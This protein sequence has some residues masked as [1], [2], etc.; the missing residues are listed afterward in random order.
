MHAQATQA[1]SVLALI[2]VLGAA[3]GGGESTK[4]DPTPS[5]MSAVAGTPPQSA[6]VGTAV[7]SAPAV[8]LVDAS[9]AGV[10]GV[11]VVFSVTA[12]GGTVEGGTAKSDVN[13]VAAVT[14][15]TLGTTAGVNTL[16]AASGN[17][18]AVT[19][20]ATGLPGAASVLVKTSTD[21]QTAVAGAAVAAAP[22][23]TVKD[24]NGNAVAGVTVTFAVTAGGGSVT[25]ATQQSS[26]TG[27]AT[28]GS[29]TL[30]TTA[31][32][33]TVTASATGLPSVSFAGTGTAGPAATLTVS[34]LSVVLGPGLTRQLTASAVDQYG[35]A[36]TTAP[37]TF[38]TANGAIA[39]VS[40]AGLVSG[41]AIGNTTVTITSGALTKTAFVSV[42]GHP[43]GT[44]RVDTP[45]AGRP[46]AVR[47]SIN[48]VLLVGEQD[49]DLLGRYNLPSTT[50]VGSVSVGDD[51][52]DVNFSADGLKAYVTNQF[53]STLGVINVATNTQVS[54]VNVG[55]SPFRVA[56]SRDGSKIYV[57]TG[58]GNL[59]TVNATTLTAGPIPLALGGALNGLAVH[60]TQP[61]IY[62]TSTSGMLHEVSETTGLLLRSVSTG[63]TS[64]EVV[65]SPAG[66]QLYIAMES[67]ALQ[68]RSVSDL[69]I[70]ATIPAASGTFGAAVSPDGEQLYATQPGGKVL[71]IDLATKTVLRTIDGGTPR[72][73][74]FDRTGLTALIGNE[75][76]YVSFIK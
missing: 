39:T 45:E 22:S 23:V 70:V 55:S 12:G 17:L 54:T 10:A 49:T 61:V 63:G 21:P 46:F 5:A 67:G 30:G 33:N 44:T 15:W 18:A 34:P 28:L 72:R 20:T 68:I 58:G 4:P 14:K 19:F 76:G 3:C 47:A 57:T 56:P 74:T 26:A 41:V 13:G 64:Q 38:S 8:K 36:T 40:N 6:A 2:L 73:V 52:T 48:D 60:P 29:W 51:P 1:R 69:A 35:N 25:A 50:S 27:V 16:S 42:G 59:V 31:G 65:L 32:A 71:V 66:T 7:P 9:G 24:A 37:P 75:G 53:S 62:V 11:T 43:I